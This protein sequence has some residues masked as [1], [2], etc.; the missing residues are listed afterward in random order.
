MPAAV[1]L[2]EKSVLQHKDDLEKCHCSVSPEELRRRT[3][4]LFVAC[5]QRTLYSTQ[6][7]VEVPF[8]ILNC[9]AANVIR[10]FY[11]TVST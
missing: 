8:Y 9:G 5:Y 4:F 3:V 7:F 1:K 6:T 2:I 11:L 10:S